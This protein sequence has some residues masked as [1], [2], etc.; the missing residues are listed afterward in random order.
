MPPPK[1]KFKKKPRPLDDGPDAYQVTGSPEQIDLGNG[2]IRTASV[3]DYVLEFHCGSKAIY[4]Q[5]QF[6]S[7]LELIP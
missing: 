1:K 5:A 4:P 6:E 2:T 3:G 7:K